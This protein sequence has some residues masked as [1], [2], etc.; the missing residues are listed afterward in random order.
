MND[1][2]HPMNKIAPLMAPMFRS[3]TQ[4]RILAMLFA[5]PEQEFTLND[6]ARAVGTSQAT[7][8]REIDRAEAAGLVL[9]HKAGQT[10]LVRVDRTSRFFDS[11]R[12]LVLGSFG[13]PAVIGLEFH[14]IPGVAAM[15]LFGSWVS[16]YQGIPGKP[17]RDIDVLL[18]GKPDR[19][20]AYSAAER[21]EEL[22]GL[23]IQVTI[24][25]VLEWS[26]PDPF[27]NE[28]RSRPFLVL[29]VDT[30]VQDVSELRD[31]L[32]AT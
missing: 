15:V 3:D 32:K 2:I 11:M 23:P 13:A 24:R 31:L 6:L 1:T 26:N 19:N 18:I 29:A 22:L 27:L 21:A 9:T 28:V 5:E 10:R 30:S 14:A 20:Q 8:W 16:R 17:P 7:V 4:G 25:S 12:E